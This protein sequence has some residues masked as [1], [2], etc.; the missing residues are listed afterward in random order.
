MDAKKHTVTI[1]HED[2]VEMLSFKQKYENALAHFQLMGE[3]RVE[4][5]GDID[6][7]KEPKQAIGTYYGADR[8]SIVKFQY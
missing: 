1:P 8:R 6:L 4:I 5:E 2:Y 3:A 7:S